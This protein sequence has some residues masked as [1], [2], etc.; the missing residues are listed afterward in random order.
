MITPHIGR[1]AFASLLTFTMLCA[2]LLLSACRGGGVFNDDPYN[3]NRFEAMSEKPVIFRA[4]D[5]DF[6]NYSMALVL[7]PTMDADASQDSDVSMEQRAKLRQTLADDLRASFGDKFGLATTAG[8]GVLI[9]ESE[10]V[11]AVPNV[12]ALNLAPQTQLGHTGYGYAAIRITLRDGATNSAK[13]SA[14]NT[15][16]KNANDNVLSTFTET[17]ATK[18]FG[19]DKL[20]DWGS[21][22]SSFKEWAKDAV[23]LTK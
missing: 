14:T 10:I 13:N 19:L 15:A 21:I 17:R 11:R 1:H 2:A 5:A 7:E 9:V 23:N 20:S 22:E 16:T 18:R 8:P 3:E 12:P 4:Q 6:S